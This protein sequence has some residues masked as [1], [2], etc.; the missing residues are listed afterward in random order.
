[1]KSRYSMKSL[2]HILIHYCESLNSVAYEIAKLFW[3]CSCEYLQSSYSDSYSSSSSAS[4][5]S[6]IYKNIN[7]SKLIHL[8]IKINSISI[9]TL[10]A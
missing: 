7:D 5:L 1:M 6:S 10:D 9:F 8:L 3:K 2:Y 4:C